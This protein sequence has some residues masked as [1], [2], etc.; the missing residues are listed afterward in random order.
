M[1]LGRCCCSDSRAAFQYSPQLWAQQLPF[2]AIIFG[3]WGKTP[4]SQQWEPVFSCQRRKKVIH[5]N[6]AIHKLNPGCV[7]YMQGTCNGNLV[8]ETQ[9]RIPAYP[10]R[11]EGF[12]LGNDELCLMMCTVQQTS[13][14]HLCWCQ[15]LWLLV[16]A[17]TLTMHVLSRRLPAT[18]TAAALSSGIMIW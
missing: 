15:C 3:G 6:E 4:K 18:A 2:L 12:S 16:W 7:L 1:G 14:S 11:L 10:T 5:R 17:Q 9:G 8:P 13:Y